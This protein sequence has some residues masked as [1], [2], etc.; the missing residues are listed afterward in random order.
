MPGPKNLIKRMFSSPEKY[1]Q[2]VEGQ[3]VKE[4]A[5]STASI[6]E[7]ILRSNLNIDN[8]GVN[9]SVDVALSDQAK[10][11]IVQ[12]LEGQG[13]SGID[14]SW[15]SNIGLAGRIDSKNGKSLVTAETQLNGSKILSGNIIADWNGNAFYGQVPEISSNYIAS[16]LAA[17]GASSYMAPAQA[18]QLLRAAYNACPDEKTAEKLL[19]KYLGAV[20]ENI[21]QVE[22][23]TRRLS[24]GNISVNY[25]AL[26]VT[27]DATTAGKILNAVA[28]LMENDDELRAIANGLIQATG[29]TSPARWYDDLIAQMRTAAGQAASYTSGESLLMTVYVDNKG[30]I[31]GRTISVS[32]QELLRIAMPK[33]GSDVGVDIII[34]SDGTG[35]SISGDGTESK[36]SLSGTFGVSFSNYSENMELFKV[37]VNGLDLKTAKK[38][39]AN[40]KYS[41][42]PGRDFVM[43][44]SS[45]FGSN[46][47]VAS[48]LTGFSLDVEAS[49]SENKGSA[50][51]GISYNGNSFGTLTVSADA[52]D[53]NDIQ[54][55]SSAMTPE[56]YAQEID[57][58]SFQAIIQSLQS[59]G[60]P[61]SYTALLQQYLDY[62]L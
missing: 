53:G 14:V 55:I 32:G 49:S 31:R 47:V 17:L 59:A 26:D 62:Y 54:M 27:I 24:A 35:M 33:K 44:L 19:N 45:E 50:V 20:V 61:T 4:A 60:V 52:G 10:Q 23:S 13:A 48:M 16:D 46:S 22:K 43:A 5:D 58:S 41:I 38:G 1:Y 37:S 8:R 29:Q 42:S 56:R 30:E 36:D 11:L 7:N 40:G 9:Y 2:Y 15:L 51:I 21:E 18:L 28:D 57:P 3:A 39:Y 25:T 12:S 34:G 6:Y